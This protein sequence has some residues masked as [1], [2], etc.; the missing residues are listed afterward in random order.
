[1]EKKRPSL[2]VTPSHGLHATYRD[3]LH[4]KG[5]VN[6]LRGRLH[7]RC[8][9]IIPIT[10]GR[11]DNICIGMFTRPYSKALPQIE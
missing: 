3:A 9:K 10:S 2:T 4:D 1:M 6:E 5:T 11:G 7:S 8:S